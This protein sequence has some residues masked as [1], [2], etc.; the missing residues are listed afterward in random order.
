[1]K[2]FFAWAG[3]LLIAALFVLLIVAVA[4]GAGSNVI[5]ALIFCIIV[6]PALLYAYQLVYKVLKRNKEKDDTEK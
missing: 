3:L 5:M 4:T 2:R 1:M 6:I